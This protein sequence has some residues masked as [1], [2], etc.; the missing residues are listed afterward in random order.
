[1]AC[2]VINYNPYNDNS[3]IV[4]KNG[5]VLS[6]DTLLVSDMNHISLQRWFDP[7]DEWQG[8]GTQ[9][10]IDNNDDVCDVVFT[11]REI[12][13]IDLK[14]YFD[15]Q[16][17][18][19]GTVFN[20]KSDKLIRNDNEVFSKLKDIVDRLNNGKNK[21]GI[22]IAKALD[23]E[24][25]KAITQEFEKIKTEPFTLT[26]LATMS[27]GKSTLLNALLH[28]ELLPTGNE[29]TTA[30]IVEI[31]DTDRQEC[32]AET[33]DSK[34]N[35][36]HI[37]QNVDL[38]RITEFNQDKQVKK[39]NIYC[40][41]PTVTN[42]DMVLMLRD[43]PGPNNSED[44][45]HKRI[46]Q[47]IICPDSEDEKTT[48]S[49]VLYVMNAANPRVDSDADLLRSIANEMEKGGKQANERFFFVINK[50][51]ERLK[52]EN[53]TMERLIENTKT[54]LE[55]FSIFNP[56]IF[57]VTAYLAECIWKKR[58]G[59]GFQDRR[60]LRIY[61][62]AIED[63]SD[64]E[65]EEIKFEKAA[66]VSQHVKNLID[67]RLKKAIVKSDNEEIALIHSGI[68]SL[69]ESIKEY[70]EKYAYPTKISDAIKEITVEIDDKKNREYFL[71]IITENTKAREKARTQ[72]N[73]IV[74]KK[75]ERERKAKELKNKCNA[76][77]L[78]PK[79][80]NEQQ[81]RVNDEFKKIIVDMDN[82]IGHN[83]D[84]EQ[85]EADKVVDL[86]KHN[87]NVLERRFEAR[88]KDEIQNKIYEEATSLLKDYQEYVKTLE[89]DF[90]I[91][92]FNFS[93]VSTIKKSSF[94]NLNWAAHKQSRTEVIT[95]Q[96]TYRVYNP[97]YHWYTPW[98]DEYI[99]RTR[100]R[101]IGTKIYVSANELK[102][103]MIEPRSNFTGNIN[104]FYDD[105]VMQL[106]RFKDKFNKDIEK[107]E[108]DVENL[109]EQ[110]MGFVKEEK[111]AGLEEKNF[112]ER[113]EGINELVKEIESLKDI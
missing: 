38:K 92:N 71:K 2:Y 107:L 42:G 70:I 76:L 13:Y 59:E 15:K 109:T 46:T 81:K 8:L 20:V 36:I 16:F 35:I 110:L 18:S 69:E 14:E 53:E 1:M 49:A 84:V 51:D 101:K 96:E 54:Y 93:K 65:Y 73:D 39:V 105:A 85:E 77:T 102:K 11:G 67:E 80:K 48:M 104:S 43:T 26:V 58:A 79:I 112:K 87:I 74:K 7:N 24:Q 66:S 19:E 12:D 60:S 17:K 90:K 108:N 113:L 45:N 89:E 106:N 21:R 27:S 55:K 5:K 41:I 23:K 44:P 68:P 9:L 31:L 29:A 33:Y 99:Y 25:I 3:V 28:K 91:D 75:G 82:R 86:Y 6:K 32:E 62:N 52:H 56:R 98:R 40:D 10:E 63:F 83:E 97:N 4:K 72:I 61:N 30:N 34:G 37:K 57:P 88:L 50:V 22:E 47:R 111:K 103:A 94:M 64:E 95:K 100:T 78:D